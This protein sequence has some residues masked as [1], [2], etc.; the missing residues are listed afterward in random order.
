MFVSSNLCHSMIQWTL[1]GLSA[2]PCT[3]DALGP[4]WFL[5]AY[6]GLSLDVPHLTLTGEPRTG[7]KIPDVVSPRQSRGGG[8]PPL[9]C[10]PSSFQC[11]QGYPWPSWQGMLRHTAGSWPTCCP[12]G[13]PGPSLQRSSQAGQHLT[14]TDAYCYSSPGARLYL[15]LLNLI[16]FLSVQLSRLTKTCWTAAHTFGVSATP[17]S[18]E[19]TVNLLR[20]QSIPSSKTGPFVLPW[21]TLIITGLQLASVPVS[22]LLGILTIHP[23]M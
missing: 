4:S 16:R 5:W 3:G 1:L 7:H 10:W 11:M 13:H 17:S 8:S 18:F 23:L 20:M 2:F 15:F 12:S 14:S 9:I 6:A 22:Q 19:S 21:R